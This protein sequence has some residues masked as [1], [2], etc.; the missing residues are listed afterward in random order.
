LGLTDVWLLIGVKPFAWLNAQPRLGLPQ[1]SL[2]LFEPKPQFSPINA[3]NDL[4]PTNRG[5]NVDDYFVEV[6]RTLAR[7]CNFVFGQKRS[8]DLNAALKAAL[9][10]LRRLDVDSWCG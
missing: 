5:P 9:D 3:S 6:A 10:D 7:D 1:C 2:G 4:P 8:H